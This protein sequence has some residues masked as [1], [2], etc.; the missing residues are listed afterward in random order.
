MPKGR[1]ADFPNLVFNEQVIKAILGGSKELNVAAL[2]LLKPDPAPRDG[3]GSPGTD[4][5]ESANLTQAQYLLSGLTN[6]I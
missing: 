6:R 2:S 5:L 1:E 4:D 3:M